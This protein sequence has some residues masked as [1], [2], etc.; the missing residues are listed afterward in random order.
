MPLAYTKGERPRESASCTIPM[1]VAGLKS[2][3]KASMNRPRVTSFKVDSSAG[4][5][6]AINST[7]T[8]N[9]KPLTK[10]C[11]AANCPSL[12][13]LISRRGVACS[14]FSPD[15]FI[16]QSPRLQSQKPPQ[17]GESLCAQ[18]LIELGNQQNQEA[19]CRQR[20]Q[21]FRGKGQSDELQLR[22]EMPQQSDG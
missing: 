20:S 8:V 14:V 5:V 4:P 15:G 21:H 3:R 9:C 22:I 11:E 10:S 13:A 7:K 19:Q 12:R 18:L 1:S 2:P 17:R 16:R 6:W